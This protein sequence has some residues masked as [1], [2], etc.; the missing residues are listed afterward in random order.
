MKRNVG[1]ETKKR[2]V[3]VEISTVTMENSIE[4][5]EIC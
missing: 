5:P 2:T 3:E 1:K 4:N